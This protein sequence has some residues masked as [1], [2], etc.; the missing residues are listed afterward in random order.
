M[1]ATGIDKKEIVQICVVVKDIE[2]S[3]ALYREIL[4]FDVPETYQFTRPFDHTQTTY[5]GKPTDAAAKMLSFMLGKVSFELLQPV[6]EANVWMDYLKEHGEGVHHVTFNVPR[7][8]AAAAAFA[9][10]GYKMTQM[11]LFSG[12]RGMYSYV[13]TDKDLGVTVEFLEYYDGEPQPRPAPPFPADKGMGTNLVCQ[14]GLVVNDIDETAAC[15]REVL[16]V[17][18]PRWQQTPGYEITE[19]TFMGQ[20]SEATARLAFFDFG[21]VQIELIEPDKTPSVWRNYLDEKGQSAHHI[22]FQVQDTQ[23]VIDHFAKHGIAVAQQGLYGDR[24]GM[25]TYMDSE[26]KLG[27]IFELLESFSAPR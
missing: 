5:Y 21:Q 12:R 20:P 13:D 24:S 23:Q 11:G 2:R 4:G 8:A 1:S 17:P 7:T 6:D 19:M 27:I 3:A 10:H 16:E 18:E 25:Y 22:A 14:V 26:A 15:Y 9:D